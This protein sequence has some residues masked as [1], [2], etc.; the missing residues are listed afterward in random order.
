[1]QFD[2]Y[3]CFKRLTALTDVQRK[4]QIKT[5]LNTHT[6]NYIYKMTHGAVPR[7]P[8]SLVGLQSYHAACQRSFDSQSLPSTEVFTYF[9]YVQSVKLE[10]KFL[11]PFSI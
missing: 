5:E 6:S 3:V 4:E 8:L 7:P 1:M 9:K 11:F 10:S 2:R